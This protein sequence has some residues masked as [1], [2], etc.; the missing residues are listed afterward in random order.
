MAADSILMLTHP[1]DVVG[2]QV[3]CSTQD[4]RARLQ[5]KGMLGN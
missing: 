3:T 2:S 1:L 5:K 4:V